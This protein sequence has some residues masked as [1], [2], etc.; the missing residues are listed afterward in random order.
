MKSYVICIRDIVANVHTQPVTTASLGAAVRDFGDRCQGKAQGQQPGDM[1]AMHPE[2]FELW[3]IGEY[4]D[5]EGRL[6]DYRDEKS[7]LETEKPEDWRP[8]QLAAGANYAS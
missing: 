6:Y 4:D 5:A 7:A 1:M 8:R 3:V 2:H